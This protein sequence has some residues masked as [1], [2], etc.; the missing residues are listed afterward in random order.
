MNRTPIFLLNGTLTVII[1]PVMIL[2]MARAG[3]T[4]SDLTSL[5]NMLESRNVLVSILFSAGF[6]TVC[7]SLN[8][9]ASSAV[10]RE[11]SQFWIS[12]IIP[13]SPRD[14]VAAKFLH[15]YL[16]AGVGIAAASA[17]LLGQIRIRPAS[18][19][20]ALG[21]ALAATFILTAAGL[22]IDLARPLLDWINPQKAIKQN[23][24]VLIAFLVDLGF[25]ALIGYASRLL[26]RLGMPAGSVL[27]L[28]GLL[29]V[30]LAGWSWYL[31]GKLAEKRY[32][33]IEA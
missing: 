20:A 2:V 23:L 18:V 9:T 32:P 16:V 13:V 31:L 17:V 29:L 27:A 28:L 33:A 12:R 6:M 1:I 10:S 15:S 4:D 24:N 30:C 25:L 11:G 21:L 3:S 22:A 7:G 14:Q 19:A 8:G 26:N 5:F